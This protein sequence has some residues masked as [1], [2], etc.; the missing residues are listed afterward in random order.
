M[1]KNIKK[2]NEKKE[3]KYKKEKLNKKVHKILTYKTSVKLMKYINGDQ[4]AVKNMIKIVSSYIKN[5]I[6]PKTFVLGTKISNH[7]QYII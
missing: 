5:N 1:R 2:K 7:V 6:K 3:K 4:K